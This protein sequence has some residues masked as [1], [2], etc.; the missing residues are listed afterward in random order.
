MIRAQDSTAFI[1]KQQ[2]DN[3]VSME[4]NVKIFSFV[5]HRHAL[6]E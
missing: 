2:S 5:D 3:T 1:G 6:I 4:K